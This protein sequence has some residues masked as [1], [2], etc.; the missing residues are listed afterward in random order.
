MVQQLTETSVYEQVGGYD[1]FEALVDGFYEV[2]AED[3]VLLPLYPEAPDLSG[4]GVSADPVPRPVLGRPGDLLRGARASPVAD[5]ARPV[6]DR[7]A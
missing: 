7:G 5:A 6:R 1:F 3:P 4:R 2:V